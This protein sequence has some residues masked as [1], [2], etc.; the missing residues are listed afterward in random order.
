MKGLDVYLTHG[1]YGTR[2]WKRLTAYRAAPRW[3]FVE[4]GSWTLEVTL[5]N[6]FK[7]KEV[8]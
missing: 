8:A 5:P 6:W 3:Y 4:A 1:L 2:P 7:R